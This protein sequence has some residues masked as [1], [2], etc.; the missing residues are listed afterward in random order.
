MAESPS[1]SVRKE[2]L[3]IGDIKVEFT[4]ECFKTFLGEVL[5]TRTILILIL[6]LWTFS[7]V[8]IDDPSFVF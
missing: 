5:E 2:K 4:F 8:V 3:K 1:V 6:P 7:K